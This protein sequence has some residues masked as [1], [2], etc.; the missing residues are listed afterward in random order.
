[1]KVI[2]LLKNG[3][4]ILIENEIEEGSL[5]TRLLLSN[6]LKVSKEYLIVHEEDEVSKNQEEEFFK[7][8]KRLVDGEPIQ[9]IINSVEFMKIDFF[10][11]NS[12]L[13]PQP[14]TEILVE[15][16]IKICKNDNKC[17]K[18]LDLCTGSGIICVSLAKN[19]QNVKMFASDVSKSAL[20]IA[21]LNS[22]KN[23]VEIFFY[24]SDLFENINEKFDI[25]VSNPPYIETEVIKTLSKEVR[26]EPLLALDGG[27][28]GLNFYRRIA[29][30][31]KN[32]LNS[33][34]KIALEIGFNQKVAVTQIFEEQ[35]YKNIQCFKDLSN[36]DRVI[37]CNL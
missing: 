10:V 11:D 36:N 5:K 2:D 9:Y 12:V 1:M 21:K 15:K 31:A 19:L 30:E 16:V 33:N 27:K 14:D 28:D 18:I 4:K 34:G 6:I 32:Y 29:K 13:I 23:N 35:G 26:N 25:I 3:R 22:K 7:K 37:I 24:E 17:L 8:I 20:Q